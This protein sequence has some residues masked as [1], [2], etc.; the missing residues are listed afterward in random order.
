V[1]IKSFQANGTWMRRNGESI[2]GTTASP[3]ANLS[4][5]RCTKKVLPHGGTRL[6]LHLFDWQSDGGL[7]VPGVSQA[8]SRAALLGTT[9]PLTTGVNGSDLRV[10]LPASAPDQTAS[11]IALEFTE[12]LR[13][14]M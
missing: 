5:G 12:P 13:V 6:Y 2:Y 8:P 7:V 14:G 1:S 11:V 3:F 4:W 9:R 10:S